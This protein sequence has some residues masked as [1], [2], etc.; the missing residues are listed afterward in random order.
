[1]E[2]A[3][4]IAVEWRA[5]SEAAEQRDLQLE[6]AKQKFSVMTREQV[7][8][9]AAETCKMAERL[10]AKGPGVPGTALPAGVELLEAFEEV[11]QLRCAG[12]LGH[13]G[14][15]R[16]MPASI[17]ACVLAMYCSSSIQR[18]R[19]S[20]SRSATCWQSSVMRCSLQNSSLTWM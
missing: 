12:G 5:L 10:K 4:H 18:C 14:K 7:A 3:H 2:D 17:G 15:H 19:L 1:M 16:R 6:D 11:G 9:F 20:L 8:E 13:S